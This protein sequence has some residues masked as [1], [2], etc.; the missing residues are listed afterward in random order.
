MSRAPASFRQSDLARA[1]K[2]YVKAGIPAERIR[3]QRERNRRHIWPRHPAG[4]AAI[5]QGRR[6]RAHGTERDGPAGEQFGNIECQNQMSL[7][8]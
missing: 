2:A 4:G 3:L 1:I 5:H 8:L 7:T 6:S